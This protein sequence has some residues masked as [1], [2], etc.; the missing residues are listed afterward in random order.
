LA[1]IA[2]EAQVKKFQEGNPSARVIRIANSRHDVFNS[3]TA[4]VVGEI[5]E[6]LNHLN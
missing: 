1:N 2:A 4:E 5:D 3:N 6:F